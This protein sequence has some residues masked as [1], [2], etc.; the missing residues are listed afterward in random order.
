MEKAIKHGIPV[1]IYTKYSNFNLYIFSLQDFGVKLWEQLGAPKDKIV[2]GMA[3]YGRSFTLSDQ[4]ETGMNAPA[5]GG[6]KAGV[7]TREEGFLAY[8]EVYIGNNSSDHEIL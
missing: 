2:V 4:D 7:Y 8:Y 5:K 6:G 1:L 3:T